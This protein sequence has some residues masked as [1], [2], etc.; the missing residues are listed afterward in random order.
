MAYTWIRGAT[1]IMSLRV[2]SGTVTG[3]EPVRCALKKS[4]RNGPLSLDPL[5]ESLVL[6]PVFVA[7][8]GGSPARWDFTATADQTASLAVGDYVADARI[9]IS[10]QVVQTGRVGISVVER[11]TRPAP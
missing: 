1:A 9:E 11:V 3:S 7:A 5:P 2:T 10:G 6:S 8:S 4:P